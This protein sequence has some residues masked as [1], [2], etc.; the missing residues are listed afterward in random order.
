[1]EEGRQE[2]ERLIAE[3]TVVREAQEEARRL[4]AEAHMDSSR[5]RRECDDYVDGKLAEFEN[6]LSTTLRSIARDR[7]ALRA[8]AVASGGPAAAES[9]RRGYER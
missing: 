4:V 2:Q 8:G 6:T 5:L 7:S 9:R 1:M 3:S